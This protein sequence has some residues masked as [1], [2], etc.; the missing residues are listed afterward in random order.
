LSDRVWNL[1]AQTQDQIEQFLGEGL[2]QGRS[3]P[4][5]AQ[6]LKQYLQN[7]DSRYR[8]IR[9]KVTGKLKLSEP[10]KDYH[11]GQGVYRSSYKNALRLARNEVNIAYKTSDFERRKNLPFVTGI[12]VNLSNAHPAYDICDEL[13]G[14]YPK[15][16]RFTGWHVAC[17]CFTTAKLLPRSE[18]VK[19][20]NGAPIDQKYF[21]QNIPNRAA[22]Y[23]NDNSDR[24]NK[25]SNKPYFIV[26]NFKNSDKGFLLK[27]SIGE[28]I[29]ISQ[30]REAGFIS[31]LKKSGVTVDHSDTAI[32][33]FMSK[34]KGFDL[35]RMF[36]GL[37]NEL[38]LNGI[39][40][41]QKKVFLRTNGFDFKLLGRNF[42]MTR[43]IQYGEL[44]NEVYHAYLRIPEDK[45]G[46][47]LTKRMFRILYKEYEASN[48]T[49]LKV[50]ANIDVGGYAWA[51][52]GFLATNKSEILA[53]INRSNNIEFKRNALRKVQYFY[54]KYSEGKY[55]P[56]NRLTT[57]KGGK[58]ALLNSRWSGELDLT[59]ENQKRMFLNYL[60]R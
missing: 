59:D 54:N 32:T 46:G 60:F 44:S 48:V 24:I 50:T 15:N 16:F 9:D 20:L 39:D 5:L 42:E 43:N 55:F 31:Q 28:N 57:I 22:K 3:A 41:I 8:R 21:T 45:Q 30:I 29:P 36:S 35:D 18:F 33:Q 52:Y 47:G 12:D 37:E 19:H 1:N 4:K 51:R 14:G 34:A 13:Q 10:A 7:P 11:P 26:D 23:L 53:I 56:M 49:K 40:N 6:D 38:A 25:L 58:D 2:S 27:K 17:L